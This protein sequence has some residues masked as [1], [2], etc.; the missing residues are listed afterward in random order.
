MTR[1][2]LDL[3]RLLELEK[4]TVELMTQCSVLKRR[5]TVLTGRMDWRCASA[6]ECVE[7]QSLTSAQALAR[8][9]LKSGAGAVEAVAIL[10]AA[11]GK[12][13][14][15]LAPT[16]SACGPPFLSTTHFIRACEVRQTLHMCLVRHWLMPIFTVA[17]F[18]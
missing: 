4:D 2:A 7:V 5:V 11:L 6:R 13:N 10:D 15:P 14:V 8:A 12:E 17:C 18:A 1:G 3:A 9:C 16:S